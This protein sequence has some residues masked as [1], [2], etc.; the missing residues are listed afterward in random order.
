MG[1]MSPVSCHHSSSSSNRDIPSRLCSHNSTCR[2]LRMDSNNPFHISKS[3]RGI[4]SSNSNSRLP[5]HL[6]YLEAGK[7]F[8]DSPLLK[9]PI[10][11]SW[12]DMFTLIHLDNRRRLKYQVAM[13]LLLASRYRMARSSAALPFK[14]P[15]HRRIT[16]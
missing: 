15:G 2:S 6:A 10:R 5:N 14:V 9:W 3:S 4:L 16:L 12:Q 7:L 8:L 1:S 11:T 13:V